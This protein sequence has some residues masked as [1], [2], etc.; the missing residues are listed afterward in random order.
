MSFS[1]WMLILV[2]A[3]A[4]FA[5]RVLG[6]IAGDAIRSSRFAWV[7]DDLPGLIIVSLVASSLAGETIGTWL[8]AAIA[9]LIAHVTRSVILTMCAGVA[10]YGGMV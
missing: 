10:A 5:I 2:L 8:A 9:L 1:H 4:A 6:L 7:L 3:L